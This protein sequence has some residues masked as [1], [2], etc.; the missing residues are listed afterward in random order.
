[1]LVFAVAALLLSLLAGAL[2][3]PIRRLLR[4]LPPAAEAEWLLAFAGA[5]ALAGLSLVVLA[6]A[7]FLS[8]LVGIGIDHCHEHGHHMHFCL[9]HSDLWTGSA[10][11]WPILLLAGLAVATVAGDLPQRL[12]R[13]HG[14]ARTL[15]ALALPAAAPMPWRTVDMDGPLA[16]TAGLIRPR[17]FIS[18]RLLEALS[19]A[20]LAAVL[21]HEQAHR[22]RRDAVR[23]VV[24]EVLARLHLPPIRRRLLADLSLAAERA[25]DEEA[26]LSGTGRLCVAGTLLK[27]AR[28]NAAHQWPTDALIPTIT[29]ADLETRIEALMRPAPERQVAPRLLLIPCAGVILA[30]GSLYSNRLH[31]AVES[32]LHL[33]MS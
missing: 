32:A 31:H 19:P 26:A 16:L 1:M 15:E 23:Q 27:V 29:G 4:E 24:A 3:V 14:V 10:L 18:T 5:P 33:L 6:M 9:I 30:F 7:P 13:A 17:I 11:D 8:H 28:L 12:W 25:C 22:R 2:Y 20:E 21:G